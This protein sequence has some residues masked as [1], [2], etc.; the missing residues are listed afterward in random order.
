MSLGCK[1]GVGLAEQVLKRTADVCD[2]L[3]AAIHFY[4]MCMNNPMKVKTT[5][6]QI[7]VTVLQGVHAQRI[8]SLQGLTEK[9]YS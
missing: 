3:R 9:V 4:A 1:Q 7:F 5:K 6:T 2:K 8:S